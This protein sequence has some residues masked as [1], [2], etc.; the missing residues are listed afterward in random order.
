MKVNYLI[1]EFSPHFQD[2]LSPLQEYVDRSFDGN[3]FLNEMTEPTILRKVNALTTDISTFIEKTFQIK[4]S[5]CHWGFRNEKGRKIAPQGHIHVKS[6]A[7]FSAVT[8]LYGEGTWLEIKGG[9]IT[10]KTGE[11]VVL[12][13]Q[14]GFENYPHLFSKPINHGGPSD[15]KKRLI[16]LSSYKVL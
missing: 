12:I 8:C 16:F 10:T 9:R 14:T 13:E 2:V 6:E 1:H 15:E 4:T 11:T 3:V 7:S 5:C